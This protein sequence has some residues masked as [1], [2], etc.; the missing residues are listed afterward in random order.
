MKQI[1]LLINS[2]A[3]SDPT[4]QIDVKT[5]SYLLTKPVDVCK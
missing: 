5:F 4:Q 2:P 3:A 1:F